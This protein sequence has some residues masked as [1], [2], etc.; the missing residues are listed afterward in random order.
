MKR[1]ALF[2]D[3]DGVINR[4]SGY[5]HKKE[6]FVFLEGIFEIVSHANQ[7]DYLVIVIT[8]QAGIGRG[9]YTEKEFH[10]ISEWMNKEFNKKNCKIDDIFFSPYHPEY[11]V[12][13]YKRNSILRKPSPGMLIMAKKKYDIDMKSSILIGDKITDIEAGSS[14]GVGNLL[15]YGNSSKHEFAENYIKISNLTEAINFLTTN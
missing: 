7:N 8:N 9:F 11:G 15:L 3:R 10:L 1:K 14:A 2:L 13:K 4:D 6:N 12:G 5:V